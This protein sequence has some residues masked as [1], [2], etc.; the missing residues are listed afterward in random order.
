[1]SEKFKHV[2]RKLSHFV[3]G[4]VR[5]IQLQLDGRQPVPNLGALPGVG[6]LIHIVGKPYVEQSTCTVE[7]GRRWHGP[8][9]CLF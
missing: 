9:H 4:T 3:A 8:S 1:M 6:R 7:R 2:G 5:R